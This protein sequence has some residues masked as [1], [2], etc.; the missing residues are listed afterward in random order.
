MASITIVTRTPARARSQNASMNC[1]PNRAFLEDVALEVDRLLRRLDGGQH[2]GIEAI[3]VGEDLDAVLR[4]QGRVAGGLEH[5]D[6]VVAGAVDLHLDVIRD[7]RREQQHQ[8][9]PRDE[10]AADDREVRHVSAGG[11][12]PPAVARR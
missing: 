3:A 4:L 10:R 9:Q 2:R 5:V 1:S 11:A 8:D 6:E 7:V 12:A